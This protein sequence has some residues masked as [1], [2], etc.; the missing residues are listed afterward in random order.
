M[1]SGRNEG[2]TSR[3]STGAISS[4]AF[5]FEAT[6]EGIVWCLPQ[7]VKMFRFFVIVRLHGFRRGTRELP[8]FLEISA[9]PGTPVGLRD[10]ACPQSGPVFCGCQNRIPVQQAASTVPAVLSKGASHRLKSSTEQIVEVKSLCRKLLQNGNS[11]SKVLSLPIIFTLQYQ[12]QDILLS[13]LLGQ[14]EVAN[15]KATHKTAHSSTKQLIRRQ[16]RPNPFSR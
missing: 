9:W 6:K 4:S 3:P 8:G 12:F 5:E 7:A 13:E 15:Q 11:R 10:L 16:K 1:C 14:Q 2:G